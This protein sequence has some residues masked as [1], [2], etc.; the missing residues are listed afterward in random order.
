MCDQVQQE[1]AHTAL[2]LQSDV[3]DGTPT[4]EETDRLLETKG[5]FG[6]VACSTHWL[7][8]C[9]NA[10]HVDSCHL[11]AFCLGL[12]AKFG[13]ARRSRWVPLAAVIGVVLTLLGVFTS[14]TWYF[15]KECMR[16]SS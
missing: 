3:Q 11:R 12:V 9:F 1:P 4:A 10:Q 14:L 16:R 13:T 6:Y 7:S 2:Q 8:C 15:G 5:N